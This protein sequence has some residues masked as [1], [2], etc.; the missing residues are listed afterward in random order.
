[1]KRVQKVVAY[2]TNGQRLL[3]FTH[4]LSPE[5]GIQVPAGT[6]N[7]TVRVGSQAFAAD[8]K[9]LATMA[10]AA[11]RAQVRHRL[12]ITPMGSSQTVLLVLRF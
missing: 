11:T 3:V 6:M 7:S 12:L 1:M 10:V 5:A 4:P 2:I 8:A 9:K